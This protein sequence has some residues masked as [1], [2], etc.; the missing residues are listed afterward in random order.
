MVTLSLLSVTFDQP[1]FS[2]QGSIAQLLTVFRNWWVWAQATAFDVAEAEV[3]AVCFILRL[4]EAAYQEGSKWP[5]RL[6]LLSNSSLLT[7][8][9]GEW[10]RS[11]KL[12]ALLPSAGFP[13]SWQMAFPTKVNSRMKPEASTHW[14]TMSW[15][16]FSFRWYLQLWYW[17]WPKQNKRSFVSETP[18]HTAGHG[19]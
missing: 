1:V 16:L 13:C 12:H 10:A 17:P 19:S 18:G 7:F 14:L 11:R 4:F 5:V 9:G 8:Q 6:Q 2:F 15:S 3:D